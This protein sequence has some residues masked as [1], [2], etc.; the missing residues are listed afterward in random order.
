MEDSPAVVVNSAGQ[1]SQLPDISEEVAAISA[2]RDAVL[3]DLRTRLTA[4]EGKAASELGAPVT[5]A[6]PDSAVV[7]DIQTRLAAMESRLQ[8]IHDLLGGNK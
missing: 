1:V 7:T 8:A 3:A 4:L 5:T 2:D 6:T